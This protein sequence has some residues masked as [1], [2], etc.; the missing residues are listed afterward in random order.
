[1]TSRFFLSMTVQKE[2][3][4]RNLTADQVLREALGV[5]AEGFTAGDKY[6]PEG[7][8]FIAWYKDRALSAVVK[9][10]VIDVEGK[11]YTSLSGAAAHY[12]GRPTT[13][14]WDFWS[15]RI[16]GR[17]EFVPAYKAA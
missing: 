13:N 2:L 15:V 7:T 10:G 16:P 9:N 4:T 5:K 12:T 17:T 6:F 1:M 8:V 11:S 3:K 14:G